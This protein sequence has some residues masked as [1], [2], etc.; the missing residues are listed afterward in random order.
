MAV[1][2]QLEWDTRMTKIENV[3]QNIM[4][5]TKLSKI[6]IKNINRIGNQLDT[7]FMNDDSVLHNLT[8]DHNTVNLFKLTKQSIVWIKPI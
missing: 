7:N 3:D 2:V 6:H 4:F 1:Q 5:I 8:I